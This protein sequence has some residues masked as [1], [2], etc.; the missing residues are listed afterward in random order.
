MENLVIVVGDH[1]DALLPMTKEGLRQLLNKQAWVQGNGDCVF[2]HKMKT[3]H[4]ENTL[5]C[6]QG[7][8]HSY[9]SEN[10]VNIKTGKTRV[11]WIE[12]FEYELTRR[13]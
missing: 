4:I 13:Q 12:I 5:K 6:L 10:Y 7:K 11:E 9:I 3:S 2:V 8:G 1:R